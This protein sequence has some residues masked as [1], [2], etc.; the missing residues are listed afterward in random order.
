MEES[1]KLV[2]QGF[3]LLGEGDYPQALSKFDKAI[4]ADAKNAEA[5]F[6]KA[7]A[8]VLVSKISTVEVIALYKKAIELDS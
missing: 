5:Y 6:G 2:K 3:Q 1:E 4:K 8:G 7:E